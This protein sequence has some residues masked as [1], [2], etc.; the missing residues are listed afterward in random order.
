MMIWSVSYDTHQHERKSDLSSLLIGH[1]C[2]NE[3]IIEKQYV[4]YEEGII[5]IM[6][7]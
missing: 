4:K 2:E 5:Q 3:K 6:I 7:M 1:G